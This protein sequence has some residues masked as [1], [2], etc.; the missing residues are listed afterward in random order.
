MQGTSMEAR[1][2]KAG[3]KFVTTHRTESSSGV[4]VSEKSLKKLQVN[5]LIKVL[6]R[7]A[8]RLN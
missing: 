6:C 8:T 5:I 2:A 3:E 1:Y 7:I 4:F